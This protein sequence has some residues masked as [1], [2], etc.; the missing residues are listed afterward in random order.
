VGYLTLHK[1]CQNICKT[2]SLCL[3]F[4]GLFHLLGQHLLADL[5][6]LN[7]ESSNNALSH[8]C[9]A[10]GASISTRHGFLTSL[11]VLETVCVHVLDLFVAATNEQNKQYK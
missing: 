8:A 3:N 7:Q 4:L 11:G 2:N 5:L 10:A 1:Y 9:V 6:F